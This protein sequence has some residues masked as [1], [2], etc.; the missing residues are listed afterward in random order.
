SASVDINSVSG[1]VK[2]TGVQG[3]LR[4]ETISGN[5]ATLQTPRLQSAKT[6]SGDVDLSD[7]PS[8]AELTASSVSG[9]IRAKGLKARSLD[10]G[11]V[12][13]DVMLV[14]VACERVGIRSTSGSVEYGGTLARRGRYE[15][16]SHSGNVRFTLAG[17]VGF[18]LTA[19]SFSGSIRSD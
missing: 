12:S 18:E 13:G 16:N 1:S 6:V 17:D 10:V 19:S 9:T 14:D 2:V 15:V 11:T 5:I 4:A 8:D 3:A 7:A